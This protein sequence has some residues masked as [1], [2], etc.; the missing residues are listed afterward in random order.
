MAPTLVATRRVDR[1]TGTRWLAAAETAADTANG[2]YAANDGFTVVFVRNAHA[3]LARTITFVTQNTVDGQAI[4]DLPQSLAA[5]EMGLFG[6]FP[7]GTY[8]PQLQFTG[9]T[10]DIKVIVFSVLPILRE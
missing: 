8:G 6:P 4:G 9:S 5:L 10:T 1:L 3:T 2:N 7:P